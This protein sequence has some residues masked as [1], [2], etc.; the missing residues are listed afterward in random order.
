MASLFEVKMATGGVNQLGQSQYTR[1]FQYDSES[2]VGPGTVISACVNAGL[3]IGVP[4][5]TSYES[6]NFAFLNGIKP[7]PKS[8]DFRSWEIEVTY[9]FIDEQESPSNPLNQPVERSWDFGTYSEGVLYDAQGTP[10]LNKCGDAFN[11]QDREVG[12]PILNLVRN[13]ASFPITLAANYAN[14]V[15]ATTWYGMPPGTV[16]ALP[17]QARE[18]PHQTIGTYWVVTYRFAF[19]AGDNPWDWHLLNEGLN[20]IVGGV[21]RKITINGKEIDEPL[22]LDNDGKLLASGSQPVKLTFRKY[23]RLPFTVFNF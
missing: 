20:E 5:V 15:N 18:T 2:L 7:K 10:L 22:P 21:K 19:Q 4:Y 14:K 6:D 13:E 9:G 17:I 8:N 23:N 16:L 3:Y 12:Y 1:Y 11:A